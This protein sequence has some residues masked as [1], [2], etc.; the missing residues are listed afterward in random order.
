MAM[1]KHDKTKDDVAPRRR[2]FFDRFFDD[3]PELFRRPVL[4]WPERGFDPMRVEEF[5]EDGTLVVRVEVAGVDPDKDI[6]VSVE[7]DALHIGVERREEEKKEGRN[8]IRR[9]QR[10]GSFQR[11]IPLPKGTSDTD[12]KANY[13]DGILEV[14]LPMTKPEVE[15]GKRIPITK[16]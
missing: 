4:L 5:I 9:E 14:R 12:I 7:G 8:Y 15:A 6:E 1:E 13:N 11:D 10:Y 16:G 2:D 3:W